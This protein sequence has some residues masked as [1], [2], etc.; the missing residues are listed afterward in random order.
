MTGKGMRLLLATATGAA[1]LAGGTVT[2]L[3]PAA[4][5]AAACTLN[6]ADVTAL[7]VD[8]AYIPIKDDATVTFE[9]TIKDPYKLVNGTG[10]D[11]GKKFLEKNVTLLEADFQRTGE[12]GWTAATVGQVPAPPPAPRLP[13][14]RASRSRAASKSRRATRTASGSSA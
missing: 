13:L 10:D 14:R 9:A 12:T 11:A 3:T 5:A 1:V 8:D 6:D 7:T 4:S 2:I